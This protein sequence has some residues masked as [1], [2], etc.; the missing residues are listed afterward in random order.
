MQQMVFK[1]VI[2]P[3]E[4]LISQA[5]AEI[6]QVEAARKNKNRSEAAAEVTGAADG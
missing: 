1:Q 5:K 3:L 4:A 2:E 6:E